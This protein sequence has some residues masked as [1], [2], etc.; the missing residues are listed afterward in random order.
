MRLASLPPQ[1][2]GRIQGSL[3]GKRGVKGMVVGNRG[4]EFTTSLEGGEGNE[5]LPVKKVR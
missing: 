2:E 1:A 5:R 4:L 3:F